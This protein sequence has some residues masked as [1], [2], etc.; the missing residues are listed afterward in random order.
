M[1]NAALFTLGVGLLVLAQQ[2]GD[3]TV[4]LI[5]LPV[6]GALVG[7]LLLLATLMALGRVPRPIELAAGGLLR[8]IMLFLM[9]V[10]AGVLD[11]LG[12]LQ[13]Q[14]LPFLVA[15]LLGTFLTLAVTAVLLRRLLRPVPATDRAAS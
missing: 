15:S 5:G 13:G 10:V 4:D 2:A 9:P 1:R 3:L 6:P 11:H 7:M 12:L 8:H 14:W